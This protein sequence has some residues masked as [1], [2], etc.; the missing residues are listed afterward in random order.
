VYGLQLTKSE[1][2]FGFSSLLDTENEGVYSSGM[3]PVRCQLS[4][5]LDFL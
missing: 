2:L 3:Q 1:L 4:L 5:C